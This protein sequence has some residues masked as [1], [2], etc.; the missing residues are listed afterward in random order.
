MCKGR[1]NLAFGK[2]RADGTLDCAVHLCFISENSWV[3]G[4]RDVQGVTLSRARG[5]LSGCAGPWQ[6][7]HKSHRECEVAAGAGDTA[8]CSV[9]PWWPCSLGRRSCA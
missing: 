5:C 9:G 8:L 3:C 7:A 2:Q 6:Q 1:G 4:G